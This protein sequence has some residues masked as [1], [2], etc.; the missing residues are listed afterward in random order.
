MHTFRQLAAY[1]LRAAVLTRGPA[2]PLIVGVVAMLVFNLASL[3]LVASVIAILLGILLIVF[4][5]VHRAPALGL[6]GAAYMLGGAAAVAWVVLGGDA[7]GLVTLV[8]QLAGLMACGL[9]LA[10]ARRFHGRKVRAADIGAGAFLWALAAVL[11]QGE[12]PPDSA[13][14]L[15]AGLVAIYAALTAGELL[16]ERRKEWRSRWPVVGIALAH[17]FVL[18]LPVLAGSVLRLQT[19]AAAIGKAWMMAFAVELT[20][21]VVASAFVI[22]MLV[23]ERTLRDHRNAALSDPL[24]GLLNRRGFAEAGAG[25]LARQAR[26]GRGISVMMCDLDHFKRVNDRF[27][28]AAGDDLLRM[29]AHTLRDNLRTGDIV[30]RVGGEEFAVA[31]PCSLGEAAI[32]ADRVRGVF[33]DLNARVGERELETTVSIGIASGAPGTSVDHLMAC[34]DHALYRAKRA[35]RNRVELAEDDPFALQPG[36]IE[37]AGAAPGG[38]GPLAARVA[39]SP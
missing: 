19:G 22:V 39:L 2:A 11:F 38:G 7:R 33:A 15:G 17:A 18:I 12:W 28:H 20:L 37:L 8:L 34:A 4:S 21:Y 27:G 9:V 5:R 23:T 24:T 31:M 32:A 30:G 14:T 16:R 3:S 6:W 35:G 10:A 29:F 25:L 36:R 1:R 13:F 26:A